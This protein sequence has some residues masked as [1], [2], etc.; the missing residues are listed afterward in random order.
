MKEL[1]IKITLEEANQIL[2]ALGE[3]PFRTVHQL[4]TKI[5]QQAAAQLTDAG[6]AEP[7]GDSLKQ[8]PKTV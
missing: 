2:D 4:I 7:S 8:A 5:Q 1:T 6:G 3:K